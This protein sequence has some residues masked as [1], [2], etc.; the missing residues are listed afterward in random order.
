MKWLGSYRYATINLAGRDREDPFRRY[1]S[2]RAGLSFER[3]MRFERPLSD[4]LPPGR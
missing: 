2:V 4:A 3:T 1:E